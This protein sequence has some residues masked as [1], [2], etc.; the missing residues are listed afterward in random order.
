MAEVIDGKAVAA[1][2]IA[3]VTAAV[4]DLEA[5]TGAKT[6]LAVVI[7]GD[8][9]ASHT[10]VG[11][12]SRTA[13]ECGFNSIQHTLPAETTQEELAALIGTLNG[14]AAI[15]GI[16]VQLPLPKHLDSE[17]IIQSILPEKDVDGRLVVKAGK[18]AVGDLA[19]G[20]VSCTP[21]GAM[22]FVRR[23]HG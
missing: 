10:Y 6:G 23:T 16:L 18:L 20:L 8:D 2:V 5:K 19:A 13:K 17:A 1:S 7:V 12:K 21:A 15:H 11:A 22:V 14:D 4:T 3:A 9:P